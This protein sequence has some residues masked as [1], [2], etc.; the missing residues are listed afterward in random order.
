MIR[1]N[2]KSNFEGI[3]FYMA[4]IALALEYLHE[5]DIAYRDLKPEN[6]L[7]DYYGHAKLA[8]LGLAKKLSNSTNFR[9]CTVCGTPAYM[10]PE[11][12]KKKS[13]GREV[14][15]WAYGV[16]LFELLSGYNPF[17]DENPKKLYE[18][19]INYQ[20]KWPPYIE[21]QAKV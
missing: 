18:N 21:L 15:I 11:Q 8:D 10:S 14:D 17:Y 3:L 12:M 20:I 7:V 9:T 13:Y 16:L 4:E 6:I 2:V 1:K 5:K 19:I